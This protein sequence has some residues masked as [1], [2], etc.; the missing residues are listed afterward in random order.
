MIEKSFVMAG[1]RNANI[2]C[3]YIMPDNGK[4]IKGIV[5][6]VHGLGEHSLRYKELAQILTNEGYLVCSDDHRGFGKSV[7]K[8]DDMGHIA[9]DDG[10]NLIISDMHNLME[11]TKSEYGREL[12]YF[13]FGHS[14]GSMLARGFA[15]RYGKEINGMILSGTKGSISFAE[16]F[17]IIVTSIQKFLFGAKRRSKS[18]HNISTGGYSK[19]YFNDEQNSSAWLTSDKVEQQKFLEDEYCLSGPPT[20]ATYLELSKM[21]KEISNISMID[22]MPKSLPMLIISGDKDPVGDFAKGVQNLYRIYRHQDFTN[23]VLK[24]YNGYRHEIIKEIGRDIVFND[25]SQWLK[26]HT[27]KTVSSSDKLIS[28]LDEKDIVKNK[29]MD[30]IN[31]AT[32]EKKAVAPKKAAAKKTTAKKAAPKKAAAKKTTTKK[33][34]PKKAVAKKTTTKKAT[35]KK[36]VAKKTTTKKATPKKAVAKKTTEK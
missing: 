9:D 29:K 18:L 12:D 36:A 31:M 5:Q 24:I 21:L 22:K 33:A 32:T 7:E 10:Y 3:Y 20:V 17:G 30:G 15:I 19:K 8:P 34:A 4:N 25:I 28:S 14:L 6:V 13:I 16:N 11:K 26:L 35:P 1:K 27:K 23:I 2:H